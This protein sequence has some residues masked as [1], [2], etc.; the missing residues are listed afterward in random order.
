MAPKCLF[1]EQNAGGEPAAR[2]R[3]QLRRQC[4]SVQPSRRR[5]RQFVLHSATNAERHRLGTVLVLLCCTLADA[6]CTFDY[7]IAEDRHGTMARDHVS[8][9][10][11]GNASRCRSSREAL[12]E[13]SGLRATPDAITATQLVRHVATPDAPV[14]V[15]VRINVER[16]CPKPVRHIHDLRRSDKKSA[17]GSGHAAAPCASF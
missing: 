12:A 8:T 9:F 17:E 10:G 14:L 1:I 7:A 11:G 2:H 4:V 15:D 16:R 3:R 5:L 13:A 6:A